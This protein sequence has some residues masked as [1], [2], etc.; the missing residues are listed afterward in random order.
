MTRRARPLGV[1]VVCVAAVVGDGLGGGIALMRADAAPGARL[2][3]AA[4]V[5]LP[6]AIAAV[7][8]LLQAKEAR[9]FFLAYWPV[10]QLTY[11][12]WAFHHGLEGHPFHWQTDLLNLAGY[13]A[14]AAMLLSPAARRYFRRHPRRRH[15]REA[16][17]LDQH[18]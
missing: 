16:Q 5:C 3:W 8:I 7:L 10:M 12:G 14:C 6:M 2:P 15:H 1:T 17:S 11:V 4:A 9:L 18:P 13:L